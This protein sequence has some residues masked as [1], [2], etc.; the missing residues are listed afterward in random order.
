MRNEETKEELQGLEKELEELENEYE[1][2]ENGDNEDAFDESIDEMSEVKIGR[3][4]YNA[5]RV[6]KEM[7]PIAYN[8]GLSDFND[9]R[10][11]ELEG[12]IKDKKDEIKD[13]K[14]N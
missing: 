8:C 12:E 1:S 11:S 3:L 2:L 14:E 10:M 5:S 4:E 9:E 7:D 13:L 6:L